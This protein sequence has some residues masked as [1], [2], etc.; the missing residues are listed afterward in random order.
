MATN[1]ERMDRRRQMNIQVDH[2]LFFRSTSED[3]YKLIQCGETIVHQ[4]L[5]SNQRFTFH[6]SLPVHIQIHITPAL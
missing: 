5:R 2:M 1:C 3:D 6:H 4:I